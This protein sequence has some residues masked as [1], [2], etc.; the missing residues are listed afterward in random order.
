MSYKA[1]VAR[2]TTRPIP[3]CD[4]IVMGNVLGHNVIVGKDTPDGSLCVYFDLDGQLSEE[5]CEKNDLY[6][7]KDEEGNRIEGSGYFEKNRKVKHKKFKGVISEGFVCGLDK[8][9]YCFNSIEEYDASGLPKLGTEFDELNGHKICNRYET[10]AT[11][12]QRQQ[13]GLP[14]QGNIMFKK[15]IDTS[16]LRTSIQ[17]IPEGS[18]IIITSKLHGTSHRLGKVVVEKPIVRNWWQRMF[19]KWIGE[20]NTEWDWEVV[21]GTRNVELGSVNSETLD[22]FYGASGFRYRATRGIEPAKGEV[23]Y[24]EIVGWS[25]LEGRSPI[26]SQSTEQFKE[27]SLTA[28]FGPRCNYLYG[29]QPGEAAFYVYRITQVNEDGY[30]VE[31]AW[32]DVVRRCKELGLV[33]VPVLAEFIYGGN[34]TVGINFAILGKTKEEFL[35][36]YLATTVQQLV[37]GTGNEVLSDP[38]DEN[39]I[40]EGVVLRVESEFGTTWHKEKSIVFKV[41]EG[42]MK[43]DDTVVDIEEAS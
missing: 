37:N 24:G 21:H 16:Q 26:Q 30:V 18:H 38:L 15:H 20:P 6:P 8:F 25:D 22:P 5:F 10:P 3:G 28:K 2:I 12:R 33:H 1:V 23:I 27:K 13:Q 9:N 29:C 32:H 34:H 31:L 7:R 35:S 41:L 4:N 14:K 39:T 11:I 42:L 40:R 17:T 36:E 43:E 19:A